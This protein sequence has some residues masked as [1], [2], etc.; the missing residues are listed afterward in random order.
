M[1]FG[2]HVCPLVSKHTHRSLVRQCIVICAAT[3]AALALIVTGFMFV[4]LL[5]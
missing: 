5:P 4:C 1:V 3:A 2:L